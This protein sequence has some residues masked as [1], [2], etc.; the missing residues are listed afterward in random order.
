MLINYMS[1]YKIYHNDNNIYKRV[2]V[3]INHILIRNDI[4]KDALISLYTRESED[5]IFADIFNETEKERI[6]GDK[7]SVI[8]VDEE[9]YLDDTIET[10]KKKIIREI[11]DIAFEEIYLYAQKQVTLNNEDI[12]QKLTQNRKL[13]LTQERLMQ[14]LLNINVMEFKDL[15]AKELYTYDDIITLNLDKKIQLENIPIGQRFISLESNYIYTINPFDVIIYDRFL[16]RYAEAITSTSNKALLLD[17]GD[18]YD[19]SLYICTTSEVIEYNIKNSL[20][21]ESS[22][23]IYYPYLFDDNVK[24]EELFREVREKLLVK[25]EKL[26]SKAFEEKNEVANLFYNIEN[27]L[28]YK[29]EGIKSI[30]LVIHP[31]I[32]FNIPLDIIFKILHATREIPLIKYNPA[33]KQ[34]N[35]YR[36]Y[37]PKIAKSGRKIPYLSKGTIFKLIKSIGRQKRVALYIEYSDKDSGEIIPI[38]CEIDTNASIYVSAEFKDVFSLEKINDVLNNSINPVIGHFKSYLSQSG[39]NLTE[40]KNLSENNIEILNMKYY[41]NTSLKKLFKISDIKSCVSEIW[42]IVSDRSNSDTIMRFKRVS[43][44]S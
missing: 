6:R 12:Y 17:N 2:F 5:P 3:F 20:S 33:K 44:Y 41:V 34:E 8:F 43:N 16:E 21:V 19:N 29:E 18:I 26:I 39:Y 22:I 27:R 14:F 4:S 38:T 28:E 31:P 9:I 10:I 30:E 23:K 24:S 13:D 40:F 35:I 1:T 37:A 36:L 25:N 15:E 32:T 11:P 7:T 42:N